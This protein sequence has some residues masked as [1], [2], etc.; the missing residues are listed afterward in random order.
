MKADKNNTICLYTYT[1]CYKIID[2]TPKVKNALAVSWVEAYD[3]KI[4]YSTDYNNKEV[5]IYY[6]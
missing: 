4:K 3:T 5:G 1:E 6:S 2:S